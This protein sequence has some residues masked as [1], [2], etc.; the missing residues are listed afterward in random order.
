MNIEKNKEEPSLFDRFWYKTKRI[1]IAGDVP[2]P[3]LF[4]FIPMAI[5]AMIAM[6]LDK[7]RAYFDAPTM[8]V[9]ESDNPDLIGRKLQI[10]GDDASIL[11]DP[12]TGEQYPSEGTTLRGLE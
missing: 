11:R 5:I 7:N 10:I 1:P 3:A 6:T 4:I 8:R 12:E 9:I 2:Y